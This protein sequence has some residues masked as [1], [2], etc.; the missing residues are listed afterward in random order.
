MPSNATAPHQQKTSFN[1]RLERLKR[2]HDRLIVAFPLPAE[3]VDRVS[4]DAVA[5]LLERVRPLTQSA[6]I[7]QLARHLSPPDL[8]L[9]FSALTKADLDPQLIDPKT[10][11]KLLLI[12]RERACPSL[13]PKA[14]VIWQR[15]Y[16]HQLANR[17]LSILCG[18]LEIKRNTS[19][20]KKPLEPLRSVNM[21]LISSLI[22]L[23]GQAQSKR[24]IAR[25]MSQPMS[26]HECFSRFGINPDWA[27]GKAVLYDA[28]VAGNDLMFADQIH[29]L[30]DIF[31]ETD[32]EGQA[33]ILRHF[34]TLEA[35]TPA[36]R[37][38]AHVVFYAAV[39]APGGPSAVWSLLGERER[40][41]YS[42]WA[43]RARIGSHCL[44]QPEKA[45]FYLRYATQLNRV[46]QWDT[47]TILLHFKSFVIADDRR[48]PDQALFYANTIPSQ[49]PAGLVRDERAQSPANPA[50]SHRR[51]EEI[52]R[53]GEISGIIQMQFDSEGI[54]E[55]GVLLDF[56]LQQK[57]NQASIFEKLFK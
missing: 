4:S 42:A 36:D 6:Q 22:E 9:I 40:K 11:E 15:H 41:A 54:K 14:W 38:N 31:G 37:Q 1:H 55:S 28:F 10:N 18:I 24:L 39:G 12:L 51:V 44:A 27:F 50:I 26:L 20:S 53:Q 45:T 21:P 25:L 35:L 52:L 34:L 30:A 47:D 43:G 19:A 49:H 46:E 32:L 57:Q 56:A 5:S 33:K 29:R 48:F 23:S 8:D 13:Y 3:A 7:I 2:S 17:A 16:P